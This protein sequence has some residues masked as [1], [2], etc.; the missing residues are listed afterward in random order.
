MKLHSRVGPWPY[1]Q[2]LD[3]PGKGLARDKHSSLLQ[4]SVNY[5][6]KKFYTTGPWEA[7]PGSLNHFS[8]S[9]LIL[10]LSYIPSHFSLL[11]YLNLDEN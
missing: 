5:V 8:L 4:K 2:T 3:Q 11:Q 7:N 6:R 1:P 10:P 9:S